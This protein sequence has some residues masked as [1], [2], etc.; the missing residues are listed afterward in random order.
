M[1]FPRHHGRELL[2]A[3]LPKCEVPERDRIFRHIFTIQNH[4]S[5]FAIQNLEAAAKDVGINSAITKSETIN[6]ARNASFKK[7]APWVGDSIAVLRHLAV[8]LELAKKIEDWDRGVLLDVFA[9]THFLYNCCGARENL[10]YFGAGS[11]NFGKNKV[12]V[13]FSAANTYAELAKDLE[14]SLQTVATA[15]ENLLTALRR[16]LPDVDDIFSSSSDAK[17]PTATLREL[18][19][20]NEALST[21]QEILYNA[22]IVSRQ[23]PP[24]WEYDEMNAKESEMY[25]PRHFQ[26]N[27]DMLIG[28]LSWLR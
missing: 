27:L 12:T 10:L 9:L 18:F 23:L 13:K 11:T 15:R 20:F 2:L 21:R 19:I 1:E 8:D 22:Q 25:G 3:Q 4:A 14:D 17:V 7:Y 24:V 5:R 16:T 28:M 26:M 6:T